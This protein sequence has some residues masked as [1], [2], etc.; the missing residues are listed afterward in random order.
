MQDLSKM[1]TP[2]LADYM[3]GYK[4]NTR[5]WILANEELIRR[6]APKPE[7]KINWPML[8]VLIA[9]AALAVAAFAY[10]TTRGFL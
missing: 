10:L 2:E 8:S 4:P 5:E 7:K 1:T 9:L 6:R 3:D